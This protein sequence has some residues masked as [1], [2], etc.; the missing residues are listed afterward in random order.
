MKKRMISRLKV[1]TAVL[2]AALLL[3]AGCITAMAEAESAKV[4]VT[5][6]GENSEIVVANKEITVTDADGDGALT[7]DDAL[8]A[9]HEAS[10]SGGAEAGYAT[11]MTDYGKSLMKLW[12][13][14]NGG[15]YGYYLN[16]AS[17]FSL[18]DPV[19]DGDYICAFVYADLTSWSD[20]YSFFDVKSTEMKANESLSLTLT[21]A[22]FDANWNPVENPVEGAK[23]LI[24]GKDTGVVTDAEGK[25]SVTVSAGDHV[26]TATAE[27]LTLVPPVC[28]VTARG[29]TF[30]NPILLIA[31]AVI[32]IAVIVVIVIRAKKK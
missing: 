24:D 11:A 12:G 15:S 22:G 31:A 27:G 7:I 28:T 5:I 16:D 26:V 4:N 9:A 30:G 19:K 2:A 13:V 21:A 20:M 10:F 29:A 23:I 3:L 8:I 25:A 14:E 1:M 32:V 17:A 6:I 18:D